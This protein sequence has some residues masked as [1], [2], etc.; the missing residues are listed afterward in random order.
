MTLKSAYSQSLPKGFRGSGVSAGL[1]GS[2]AKDLAL[3][4]NDGPDNFASAVF[5]T[6]QVVA[7]PVIWSRQVLKDN[8]VSAVLLNSGGANA[9]TGPDGFA[10]THKSAEGVASL[11]SI[12]SSDV[13]ICSTGLIGVRLDMEKLLAG[14]KSAHST[15]S[16]DSTEDLARAIMTTDSK[17][18]IA[19]YESSGVS[20]TGIA[21]GAGMLAPSLATML[22]VV[23]TDAKVDKAVADGI[24]AK[25]CEK[26]FNRIDSDG[27]TSTNDTVL[28][29][30][31]AASGVEVSNEQLEQALFAVAASLSKQLIADAEGHSKIISITTINAKSER[32]AVEVGRACARNNLLKCALGGEDPNWGRVLAAIGTT[33][34]VI[35]P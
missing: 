21:K 9:A 20:F 13:A 11:L 4:V 24:F 23:M 28:F 5:T 30:S 15:L 19:T 18:K 33:N 12:S 6:N 34:A 29:L 27:C 26:T 32:D 25:V 14:V 1:K 10:D 8:Q 2:G 16:T 22:S 35:D 3:I 31:S 7:A 17:P